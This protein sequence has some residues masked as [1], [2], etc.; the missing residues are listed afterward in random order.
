MFLNVELTLRPRE[1]D[2]LHLT[3][4]R[5]S[6]TYQAGHDPDNPRPLFAYQYDR[7]APFPYPRCHL[8]V[9]AA[10]DDYAQE[11][12]FSR[13]HLPTRRITLEQIVWHLIQEHHVEPRRDDW[14]HVLWRHEEWF[15][16]IQ[17][18][19]SWPY[20]RPFEPPWIGEGGESG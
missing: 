9:F 5:A 18:D 6:F 19:R 12:P 2:P 15:R 16:T 3:T 13:L 11:R 8:H 10:P 14:R 4:T 7:N 20:D 1:T 17:Q